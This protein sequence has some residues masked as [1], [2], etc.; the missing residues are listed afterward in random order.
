MVKLRSQGIKHTPPWPCFHWLLLFVVCRSGWNVP[1]GNGK[2]GFN[3][4]YEIPEWLRI[5]LL[6]V[7]SIPSPGG[8]AM[9]PDCVIHLWEVQGCHLFMLPEMKEALMFSKTRCWGLHSNTEGL[10]GSGSLNLV[11][12]QRESN[13]RVWGSEEFEVTSSIV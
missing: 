6:S 7:T 8:W 10:L 12:P 5:C 11:V 9:L 13:Y 2:L 1:I 3:L 4:G